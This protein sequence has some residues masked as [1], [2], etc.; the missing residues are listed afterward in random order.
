MKFA[1]EDGGETGGA[2]RNQINFLTA[3]GSGFRQQ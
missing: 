3:A 1:V 2:V